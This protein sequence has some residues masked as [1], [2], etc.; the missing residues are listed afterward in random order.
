VFVSRGLRGRFDVKGEEVA[1]G[2]RDLSCPPY[3]IRMIVIA[4]FF[5]LCSCFFT[6]ELLIPNTTNL[7]IP[8]ARRDTTHS[9]WLMGTF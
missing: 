8:L 7:L 9:K 1:G 5:S 3:V 4:V 2:W 6:A